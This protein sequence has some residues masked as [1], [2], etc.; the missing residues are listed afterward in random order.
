MWIL[1]FFFFFLKEWEWI[2]IGKYWEVRWDLISRYFKSI[3]KCTQKK[4][5][6]LFFFFFSWRVYP[7][8]VGSFQKILFHRWQ[9]SKL[10]IQ[11]WTNNREISWVAW[12]QYKKKNSCNFINIGKQKTFHEFF[13]FLFFIPVA[14]SKMVSSFIRN[15]TTVLKVKINS[16]GKYL[17]IFL[18]TNVKNKK[19]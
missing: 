19:F 10:S 16:V 9:I 4:L 3:Y 12:F 14:I 1:D 18:I 8:N 6:F 5:S 13:Y 7:S 2:G 11:T 15:I 17:N